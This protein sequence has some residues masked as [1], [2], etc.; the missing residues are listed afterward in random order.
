MTRLQAAMLKYGDHVITKSGH[1]AIVRKVKVRS[2]HT[3]VF[4]QICG[5]EHYGARLEYP[6][7]DI[8]KA[9]EDEE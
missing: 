4:V 2:N 5:S 8:E 9:M 6:H 3:A 1:E 7:T